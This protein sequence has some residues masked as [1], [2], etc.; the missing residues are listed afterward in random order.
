MLIRKNWEYTDHVTEI[1]TRKKEEGSVMTLEEKSFK[2]LTAK[3]DKE[4]YDAISKLTD[5]QKDI[6]IFSF[7]KTIKDMQSGT[8]YFAAED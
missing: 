2:I 4:I 7:V 5:N 6:V 3:T 8:G 1:L